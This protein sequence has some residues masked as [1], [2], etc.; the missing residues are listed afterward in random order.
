MTTLADLKKL[1][2]E[3]KDKIQKDGKSICRE[4]F[5]EFFDKHP[6]VESIKWHQYTPYFNDGDVCEF[7]VNSDASIKLKDKDD[8][9]GEYDNYTDKNPQT[10]KLIQNASE[11]VASIPDDIMLEVFGDHAEI[12]ANR[13][14]FDVESYDH[15]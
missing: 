11:L 6:D 13:D 9:F 4:L 2:K 3:Y 5:K 14:G 8:F 1:Y 10:N 12:T 15:D 7:G